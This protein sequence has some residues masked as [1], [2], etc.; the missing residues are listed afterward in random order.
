M[1]RDGEVTGQQDSFQLQVY[2]KDHYNNKKLKIYHKTKLKQLYYVGFS[3]CWCYPFMTQS[4]FS[5]WTELNLFLT[6]HFHQGHL[7]WFCQVWGKM[8]PQHPA[9]N[10]L[11]NIIIY[12]LFYLIMFYFIFILLL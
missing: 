1:E 4:L 12:K 2:L 9:G 8:L 7:P 11:E 5:Q 3:F 6:T 10:V